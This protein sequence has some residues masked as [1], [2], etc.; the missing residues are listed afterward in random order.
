M[1]FNMTLENFLKN[2][3]ISDE[4]WGNSKLDW[5]E[6]LA[7]AKDHEGRVRN[8]TIQSGALSNTLQEF[9]GVHS[10]RWRVKN[11]FNLLKKILRKKLEQNSNE[12][13]NNVTPDNYRSVVSDLIGIRVL[14]LLKEDC[15]TIDKQIRDTWNVEKV[16]IF[17]RK[18]DET[19][20]K[21]IDQGAL[22]VPH[23][24]GYRSI[25]Y[26]L[27]YKVFKEPILIEIQVRTI[28]QEGWSEIDH[29]VKYPDVSDNALLSSFMNL[30]N[31]MSGAVD[32][33]GS[34]VIELDT[35]NKATDTM[36][37]ESIAAL[38]KRDEDIESLQE[39]V[40]NLKAVDAVPKDAVN[41][42]Q[43][44]LDN[45]KNN[46]QYHFKDLALAQQISREALQILYTPF[47]T[48]HDT[49]NF[50]ALV[51]A[52]ND[53][54]K[55]LNLLRTPSQH[56]TDNLNTIKSPSIKAAE[57]LAQIS[58][59]S[60]QLANTSQQIEPTFEKKEQTQKTRAKRSDNRN[61]GGS[62]ATKN[63]K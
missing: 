8:L 42:I 48:L 17:Q 16:T 13:W 41:S 14:H 44:K 45:I 18:G 19:L 37:A 23:D 20:E 26:D 49:L 51:S 24:K 29:K 63:N 4:E 61:S 31:L 30:F 2:S 9:G 7:I 32:A 39:Q 54:A 35:S 5:S 46:D 10:V 50:S 36:I 56:L 3:S 55:R 22:E 59:S 1:S 28:F 15:I 40:N 58:S 57:L 52:N 43:A 62:N 21:I 53:L 60:A 11:T 27:A 34:F 6:M 33:M 47:S 38:A 12:K 25:H